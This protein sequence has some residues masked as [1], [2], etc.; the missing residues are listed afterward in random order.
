[1]DQP[2]KRNVRIVC[3]NKNST[4]L[5]LQGFHKPTNQLYFVDAIKRKL[6]WGAPVKGDKVAVVDFRRSKQLPDNEGTQWYTEFS[7]YGDC[8]NIEEAKKF[9]LDP[10]LRANADMV[11]ANCYQLL[12][13]QVVKFHSL[14]LWRDQNGTRLN[15]SCTEVAYEIIDEEQIASSKVDDMMNFTK[16]MNIINSTFVQD[17]KGPFKEMV[18]GFSLGQFWDIRTPNEIMVMLEGKVKLNPVAF[19]EYMDNPDREMETVIHMA[20]EG[21]NGIKEMKREGGFYYLGDLYIG[22]NL[23]EAKAYFRG[24]M[25][26]YELIREKYILSDDKKKDGKKGKLVPQAQ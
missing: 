26:Q 16:A 8:N 14:V 22:A 17:D 6:I 13:E 5:R 12:I 25:D 7:V 4:P 1:M 3:K 18:Y 9:K 10:D 20:I 21:A 11:E 15:P 19:L 24:K 23:Q 2:K